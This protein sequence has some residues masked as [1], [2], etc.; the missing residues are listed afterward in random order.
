MDALWIGVAFLCGLAARQVGLPP[1]VGYLMAG[2]ALAGLQINPGE[3]LDRFAAIGIT[4]LLFSIGLKLKLS[5]L[6]R[7][8]VWAVAS[9]H[10]LLTTLLLAVMLIAGAASGWP[11]LSDLNADVALLLGFALSF[12]STVFAVKVL[13]ENREMA[14]VYGRIA[15]GILIMQDIAAVIFLALSTGQVPTPWAAVLLLSLFPVRWLLL[16]IMDRT[17]HEELLVLFGLSVALGAYQ[18]FD[19]FGIK[20][21]LGSLLLGVM[22]SAH[23]G[24]ES[25]AKSLLNFKDIF[26]VGFF[27]SIGMKGIPGIEAMGIALALIAALP[28]K[29]VLYFWLL[30]RL[31]MRTRTSFLAALNL[32]NYSEFGLI[33]AALAAA[34]GWLSDKWLTAGAVALALSFI[35][36][37]PL[38]AVAYDLYGRWRNRLVRFQHPVRLPDERE[39]SPGNATV[40][41]FG[42]GRVGTGAYATLCDE[43]GERIVGIDMVPEVVQRHVEAGRHVIQASATDSDFW[44]RLRLNH[45]SLRLVMLAMPQNAENVYAAKQLRKFGYSGRVVALAKYP[46]DVD[47]LEDAGVHAVFNLY[48]EAGAGFARNAYEGSAPIEVPESSP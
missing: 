35:A 38:N 21:D 1:L 7:P 43:R 32:S 27:L 9:V 19:Q 11:A 3:I 22:L 44:S 14:S 29:S 6:L 42:M 46:D 25:L 47:R 15:I 20:G 4:L 39:I 23:R 16:R 48:A 24:A 18:I 36:A 34:N 17:G 37:A 5:S 26:L 12:S 31:R 2:F 13:E 28:L 45:G 33:V 10:M 40:L 30:A 8:Q 41:I